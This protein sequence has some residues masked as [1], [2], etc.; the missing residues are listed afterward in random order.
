MEKAKRIIKC[1]ECGHKFD[2]GKVNATK[3][4]DIKVDGKKFN[5]TYFK[6][7]KCNK[8]YLVEM[9][10]FRANR[11]KEKYLNSAAKYSNYKKYNSKNKAIINELKNTL[12]KNKDEAIRYQKYLIDKYESI[13]PLSA[14]ESD[15][16]E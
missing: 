3:V 10:D 13:I 14:F 7:E 16:V 11:L 4:E 5:I 8:I 2:V 6:C 12:E 15:N 1:D 9:I